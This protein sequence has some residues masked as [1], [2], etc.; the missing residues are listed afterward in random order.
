MRLTVSALQSFTIPGFNNR[1]SG[2]VRPAWAEI[3]LDRLQ[4]NTEVV[5]HKIRPETKLIAV[6]KADAY[7]HGA[8]PAARQLLR[9]GADMLAVALASEG[10]ELRRAGIDA[11]IVILGLCD[12]GEAELVAE[13][14]L[15]PTVCTLALAER[16]DAIGSRS[17]QPI[18]IHIRIDIGLGSV[19]IAAS[20]AASFI[21][22]A[23]KLRGLRL[24]GIYT[25]LSSAY[26]DDEGQVRA[27]LALFRELLARLAASGVT[28][29]V[30]HA[31]SSPA[32]LRYPQ[33]HFDAVR[34]GILLYGLSAPDG[35]ADGLS[36]EPVMEL[37]ARIVMIK[38]LPA[39]SRIG[40]GSGQTMAATVRVATV[41]LGY[42]DGP[43]LSHL[44]GGEVLIRGRR[45]QIMGKVYMD[46]MM[47]DV[48][49][50]DEAEAG[51]EVVIFGRQ[52]EA[53]IRAEE[54]AERA[55]FG[56]MYADGVTML[57]GRIP[58]LFTGG[59]LT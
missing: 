3:H 34:T 56:R 38:E 20:E 29:P 1:G 10:A 26:G 25:H 14:R 8:V 37:K 41:P 22:A 55:G 28:F 23:A 7:G 49:G 11:P 13:Y 42:A 47:I 15:T 40:Y 27:D 21:C 57:S 52:G 9:S 16:L 32:L 48:T 31:A 33:A 24:E 30:V 5:K 4:R 6:V 17:G 39:G 19:G 45:A 51:D 54:V 58:R 2:A 50:L 12:E 35:T 36:L 18:S 53:C 44:T 43:F 46:H 59:E